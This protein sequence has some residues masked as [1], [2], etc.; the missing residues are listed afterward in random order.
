MPDVRIHGLWV[1][2]IA[3]LLTGCAD[4]SVT[5]TPPDPFPLEVY[6]FAWTGSDTAVAGV[7]LG[8]LLRVT[9]PTERGFEVR[10]VMHGVAEA[11]LGPIAETTGDAPQTAFLPVRM[12]NGTP[13]PSPAAYIG[14][15]AS[16]L[17]LTQILDVGADQADV[18]L[19][20]LASSS[21]GAGVER[22]HW[23]VAQAEGGRPAAPGDHV[24]TVTVGV[25]LNGTSFYTN[26]AELDQDPAFV[27]SYAATDFGADPLPIYV[28]GDDR[29]EQ[30]AGSADQ[31][32]F[33]T[34]KGYNRLLLTQAEGSTNV[35]LLRP[36]QAYTVEGNEGHFLYGQG[37]VFLNTVVAHDGATG[38]LDIAPDPTG[39]CF[40]AQN[41]ADYIAGIAPIP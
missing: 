3:V 9:N 17:F 19:D 39:A 13:T 2:F 4:E 27:R 5:P 22:L 40:D 23:S 29:R 14:A 35:K 1:C 36:D 26:I 12:E 32:H 38:L 30:P 10:I 7:P 37:L 41:T 21:R 20:V 34:I 31:C 33:T 24:Q 15:G 16:A 25:Y 6:R 28:Y 18:R 8:G 11:L